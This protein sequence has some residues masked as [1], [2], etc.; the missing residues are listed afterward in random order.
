[1][2]TFSEYATLATNREIL[3]N[4]L[5]R[6]YRIEV[7]Q[8]MLE[9]LKEMQFPTECGDAAPTLGFR[10]LRA[11]LSRDGENQ[12][13]DLAVDYARVFLGAGEQEGLIA[14][15]CESVYTS[16][17]HLIMQDA[18]DQVV[19]LF[20]SKGLDKAEGLDLPEDHL[21]LELEFMARMCRETQQAIAQGEWLAI[22]SSL[23]E[24]REF[25]A[26][27]LFNWV[28]KFCADVKARAE[29]EFY[30]AVA[31]ITEAFLR[32][33]GEMLGSLIAEAEKMAA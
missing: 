33:D 27:H 26:R 1:M 6:I 30:Q 2:D 5:G 32:L 8:P 9:Q 20:H 17:E 18:R 31:S 21:G 19:Q 11:Y 12:L 13:T 24:Q 4:L 28:P 16:P 10:K 14:Y 15:P 22:A 23:E 7:D 29:T 3:Y 25:I